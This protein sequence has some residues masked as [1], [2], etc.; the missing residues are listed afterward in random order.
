MGAFDDFT[1]EELMVVADGSEC[2][3]PPGIATFFDRSIMSAVRDESR[4][5]G[6][7]NSNAHSRLTPQLRLS[8]G[9]CA[10]TVGLQFSLC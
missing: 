3:G 7:N 10:T 4:E 8:D 6:A 9:T 1:P 2:R 5:W